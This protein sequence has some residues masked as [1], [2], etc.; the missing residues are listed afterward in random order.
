MGLKDLPLNSTGVKQ[1][2]AAATKIA[3]L[4]VQI[5]LTSPLIRARQT[6]T[7]I[8]EHHPH[9]PP[10]QVEYWLTERDFGPYEGLRKTEA[11]RAEMNASAQVES[12]ANLA[13]RLGAIK[14]VEEAYEHLL[15]VSHSG[16]YRCLIEAVGFKRPTGEKSLR[17]AQFVQL[18]R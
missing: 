16:V 11:K 4:P 8:A 3:R 7:I 13:E 1:A 18:T 17:N 2:E 15:I 6:A 9:S 5:I 10:V 12:L 14:E